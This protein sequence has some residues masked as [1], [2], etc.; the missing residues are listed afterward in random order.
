MFLWDTNAPVRNKSKTAIFNNGHSKGHKVI[1]LSVMRK[2]FISWAYK[3]NMKS[4]S[5]M[6]FKNQGV[7]VKYYAP[8][9]QRQQSLKTYF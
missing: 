5:L 1:D 9:Q 6:T 7:F 3:P 2:G 8:H 4:L